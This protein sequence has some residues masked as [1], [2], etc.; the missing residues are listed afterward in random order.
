MQET[1]TKREIAQA[2]AAYDS[3]IRMVMGAGGFKEYKDLDFH[4]GQVAALR[5]KCLLTNSDGNDRG[6]SDK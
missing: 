1:E 4:R 3:L 5:K 2:I 6:S